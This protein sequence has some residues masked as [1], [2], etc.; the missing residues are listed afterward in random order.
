MTQEL[1]LSLEIKKT[2]I[3]LDFFKTTL[4]RKRKSKLLWTKLTAQTKKETIREVTIRP[5]EGNPFL[6]AT[7]SKD[8][9]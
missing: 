7:K 3:R 9:P 4:A 2:H 8:Q 5:T 1:F 6:K